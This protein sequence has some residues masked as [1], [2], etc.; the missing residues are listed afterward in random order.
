M[1]AHGGSEL[2]IRRSSSTGAAGQ[3]QS[4]LREERIIMI[5]F[6]PR[7]S[8]GDGYP[9]RQKGRINE[10]AVRKLTNHLIKGV[11]RSVPRRESGEAFSLTFDQKKEMIRIVVERRGTGPVYAG[12]APSDPRGD[13][14]DEDGPGHGRGRGLGDHPL[15]LHP[16]QKS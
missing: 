12:R 1:A 15:L 16:S 9:H 2:D 10:R 5:K 7:G 3:P 6:Q 14:N 11:S 8:S 4:C 13:R